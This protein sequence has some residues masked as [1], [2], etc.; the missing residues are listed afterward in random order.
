MTSAIIAVLILL[1]AICGAAAWLLWRRI[2]ILRGELNASESRAREIG[3]FLAR[4]STAIQGE[5]GV[6]GAMRGSARHVAE[7]IDAETVVIYET[8][9]DRLIPLGVWS[10]SAPGSE[11]ELGYRRGDAASR[12]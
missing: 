6:A 10:E 11:D 5:D 7:Q 8:Q 2:G 9:D 12:R 3:E 1:L 4:F